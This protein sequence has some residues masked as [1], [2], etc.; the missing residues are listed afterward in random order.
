MSIR[1]FVGF[2]LALE[3]NASYKKG[4]DFTKSIL[5]ILGA[6]GSVLHHAGNH[7]GDINLFSPSV[8]LYFP[9]QSRSFCYRVSLCQKI[10]SNFFKKNQQDI[11][12]S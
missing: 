7:P 5:I 3:C 12:G 1:A 8:I 4:I 9:I 6:F 11:L 10:K 2:Q